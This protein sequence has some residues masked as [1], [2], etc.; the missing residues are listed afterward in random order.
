MCSTANSSKLVQ[1]YIGEKGIGFKSVFKIAKKVHIQSGP[2]SFA[3]KYERESGDHALG[4][5]TP[6]DEEHEQLPSGV[7]TRITLTLKRPIHFEEEFAELFRV[8]DTLLLFLHKLQKIKIE[9]RFNEN[10]SSTLYMRGDD[11][12]RDVKLKK[13]VFSETGNEVTESRYR[14]FEK[15]VHDL[16]SDD[17]R[18]SND[19]ATVVLAFPVDD[20]YSPLI[21]PREDVFAFL[22]LRQAGFRV[23]CDHDRDGSRSLLMD[24]GFCL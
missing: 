9:Q 16:P 5:I 6:L 7:T 20:K 23:S 12:G 15:D 2:F 17:A 24:L 14:V 21:L 13:I 18:Q 11:D 19:S 3:F 8:S 1:G 22:P 10:R 4:M